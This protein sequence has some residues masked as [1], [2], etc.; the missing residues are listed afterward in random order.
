MTATSEVRRSTRS[1]AIGLVGAAVNGAF[2]FVLTTVIVRTFGADGSGALFSVIGLVTIVGA[3]CCLGADTGL[4]WAMPRRRPARRRRGR[5]CRWRCC[6]R[7]GLS[8]LVAVVGLAR[9]RP[10]LRGRCSTTPGGVALIRLAFAG[11]PVIVAST[12][13][14][15]A[16]RATRP[17]AAYVGVQFLFVPIARPV[18]MIA[19]V[20]AGGGVLLGFAGWLLPFA[21]AL[22]IALPDR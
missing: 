15:A 16:V 22:I 6:R 21:A 13:L 17:V 9:G 10:D 1:G 14:L 20:L 12:V 19:A 7:S 2:G 18:L 4:M 8:L 11:V 5:C 3:V